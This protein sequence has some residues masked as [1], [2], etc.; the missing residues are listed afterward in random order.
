MVHAGISSSS[1][2]NSALRRLE[3]LGFLAKTRQ[4]GIASGGKLCCLYRFTDECTY[5]IAKV[6]VKA[7]PATNDWKRFSTLAMAKAAVRV[8]APKKRSFNHR[9]GKVLL[10]KLSLAFVL[11]QSKTG[12]SLRFD[13]RSKESSQKLCW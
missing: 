10:S 13:N 8:F 11:Q 7:G 3:V 1:T 4:G 6:G 5:D 9:S 2:L 12:V